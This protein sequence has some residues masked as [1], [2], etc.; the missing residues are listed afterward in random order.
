MR[1]RYR[2]TGTAPM[3]PPLRGEVAA[4]PYCQALGPRTRLARRCSALTLAFAQGACRGPSARRRAPDEPQVPASP[5]FGPRL[6]A[7]PDEG[8]HA[9]AVDTVAGLAH[10]RDDL[11]D[12]R[13]IGRVTASLVARRPPGQIAGQGDGGA[14]AAGGIEQRHGHGTSSVD[15]VHA[16]ELQPGARPLSVRSP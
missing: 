11:L 4:P 7:A 12:R 16:R 10:N 2:I 1:R 3:R 5:Q 9:G 14:T 8:P 6:A 15:D 13:R